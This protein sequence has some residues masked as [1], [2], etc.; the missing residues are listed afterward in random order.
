M[1]QSFIQN[2]RQATHQINQHAQDCKVDVHSPE[3]VKLSHTVF[4]FSTERNG[5]R[6]LFGGGD[7]GSIELS[8]FKKKKDPGAF[9]DVFNFLF[10]GAPMF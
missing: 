7:G 6:M 8:V 9:Y 2:E 5:P 10:E 4:V 1:S 3:S